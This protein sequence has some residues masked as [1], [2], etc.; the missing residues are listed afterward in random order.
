[1]RAELRALAEQL[2]VNE[3]FF[4]RDKLPFDHLKETVLPLIE[5]TE[6]GE[7][8]IVKTTELREPPPVALTA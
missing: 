5:Q 6:L 2:T 1:M 8:S 4:F 7:P 3:T